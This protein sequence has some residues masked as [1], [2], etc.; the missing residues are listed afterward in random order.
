MTDDYLRKVRAY[1]AEL[2]EKIRAMHERD[3]IRFPLPHGMWTWQ[4]AGDGPDDV[5][6]LVGENGYDDE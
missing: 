5:S 3:P 2:E 6:G 4:W 1:Q